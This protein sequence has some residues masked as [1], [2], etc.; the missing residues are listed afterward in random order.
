MQETYII[1]FA[2]GMAGAII[3]DI[4]KDNALEIPKKDGGRIFLGFIGGAITGGFVGLLVDH[5]PITAFMSGY[6]GS[7]LI[8]GL[9]PKKGFIERSEASTIED[10][11]IMVAKEEGV[12]PNLALKVAKC[13]SNLNTKAINVNT[14]GKRDRGLFQINEKWHPE[15]TD[16]QAFD[17]IF[18]TRF[19]CKAFKNG[20]LSWWNATRKCW[21]K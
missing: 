20:N 3:K 5:N 4:I 13:E 16:E 2:A 19:F 9:L 10:I 11:I 7:S 21:E 17:P 14:D 18:S 1:L 12:D 8:A 6:T 15:V